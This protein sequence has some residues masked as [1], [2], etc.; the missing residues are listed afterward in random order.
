MESP[1]EVPSS[2]MFLVAS[3]DTSFEGRVLTRQE[4]MRHE[5]GLVCHGRVFWHEAQ[6]RRDHELNDKA[7]YALTKPLV[8]GL[9]G[10]SY[11]VSFVM[12][13]GHEHK[14]GNY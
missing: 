3:P 1:V 10:P 14:H 13:V 12:L 6:H 4:R 2:L 7:I 9:F 8:Q 5:H 11:W